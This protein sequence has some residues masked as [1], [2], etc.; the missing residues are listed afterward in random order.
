M[1]V[2][3]EISLEGNR[4]IPHRPACFTPDVSSPLVKPQPRRRQSS[5]DEHG[6]KADPE[7]MVGQ[8]EPHSLS[9]PNFTSEG[10]K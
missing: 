5:N 4:L 2:N 3:R 1:E 9:A 7:F 8:A 6:G 10:V